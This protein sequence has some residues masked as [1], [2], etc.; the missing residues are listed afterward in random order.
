[1]FLKAIKNFR[2]RK[3]IDVWQLVAFLNTGLILLP[4]L[5]IIWFLLDGPGETWEHLAETVLADYILN[6]LIIIA[7][8]G[9]ISVILGISTAWVVSTCKFP[10]R[11]FFEWSLVLPLAIPTY[12]IA[13]AYA[14]IFDYTGSLQTLLRNAG[15]VFELDIM[16]IQGI[17]FILAF[18]LYPYVYVIARASFLQR[19]RS[20]LEAGRL[21]GSS[22]WRTFFKISL[23]V[24]RP[25]IIGG[26]SLVIMEV[27]N[28]YGAVKYYGVNTFT[29]GIFR[30]WF[31]LGDINAAVYLSALLIV[32]IL[33]VMGIERW[34]RGQARFDDEGQKKGKP[35]VRYKLNSMQQFLSFLICIIPLALGFVFPVV[36]LTIWAV[37]SFDKIV[38]TNFVQLILNSFGLA[39]I[40]A[41][42]CVIISII[43][44]YSNRIHQSLWMKG[45]TKTSTIGY[46]IPGAVIAVGIMIPVLRLDK[47]ITQWFENLL[48]IELGLLLTGTLFI[49]VYAYTVRFLAVAYNSV[50]AGFK[51]IPEG[52]TE[53]SR[54]LGK[55]TFITLIRVNLPLLKAS[56]ISGALLVFVDVLKELPLTLILRPFNFSTLATRAF[57]LASDERIGESAGPALIIVFTGILPVILLSRLVTK[58]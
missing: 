5:T 56:A 21:M 7:G 33:I 28:D 57:E 39:A 11:K 47:F 32:T 43:L 30:A 36:Q 3:K 25:A 45:L 26:L 37:Q 27:L 17:V 10:M 24:A 41:V 48:N 6:S 2:I 8:T 9:L 38:T 34:Q 20:M 46:S 14:G 50:D 53:A 16:N 40:S 13:F 22:S 35:P 1:M 55:S 44:I 52:L 15:L 19:S 58:S 18:V 54:S 23:P 12:I 4:I 49:L 42:V 31:S 29:T 51:K